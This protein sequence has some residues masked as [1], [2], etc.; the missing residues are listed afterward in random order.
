MA[1]LGPVF[2]TL[3]A[4]MLPYVSQLVCTADTAEN[5]SLE[6]RHILKNKQ[7]LWFGGVQVKKNTS[8]TT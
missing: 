6:T 1:D 5:L 7:P 8:A 3:R 2:A 4:I